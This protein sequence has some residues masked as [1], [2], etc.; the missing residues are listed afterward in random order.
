MFETSNQTK[1][2]TKQQAHS[3]FRSIALLSFLVGMICGP[4]PSAQAYVV[5]TSPVG[6]E[7]YWTFSEIPWYLD[8]NGSDDVSFEKLQASLAA[9]LDEWSTAECATLSFT[10]M[11]EATAPVDNALYIR[12][13]EDNFEIQALA[14]AAPRYTSDGKVLYSEIVFNGMEHTWTDIAVN[15]TG[16]LV[17]IQA[18]ATHEIG[19]SLGLTHPYSRDAS[20]FFTGGG[21]DAR[22]LGEDDKRGICYLFPSEE[23]ISGQPCDSCTQDAHCAVGTCV[24]HPWELSSFCGQDCAHDSDCPVDYICT[25][26]AKGLQCLPDHQF[27]GDFG[28]NIPFGEYCWD[29]TTCASGLCITPDSNAYC[30]EPCSTNAQCPVGGECTQGYC[31]RPACDPM[32]D[33]GCEPGKVCIWYQGTAFTPGADTVKGRCA[34][35]QGGAQPGDPCGDTEIQCRPNLLCTPDEEDPESGLS[36]CRK[37]CRVGTHEG[38]PSDQRCH[39]LNDSSTPDRGVCKPYTPPAPPEITEPETP[40]EEKED[41]A[42]STLTGDTLSPD[43]SSG[44]SQSGANPSGSVETQIQTQQ[45]S[46]SYSGPYAPSDGSSCSAARHSSN[47]GSGALL[48]L[49]L[50]LLFFVTRRSAQTLYQR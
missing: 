49:L 38:C 13:Q 16:S 43:G 3:F 27:C 1:P 5:I 4:P 10:Y 23:F 2:S 25:E 47:R 40:Q 33:N 42:S 29:K 15:A 36:F 18:V 26:T 46:A 30:S 32:Q 34:N 45:E 19:H 35:D 6:S 39:D 37:D 24:E 14:Y 28:G 44:T 8:V 7:L 50:G 9:A 31:L 20:M 48:L 17:D 22:K 21:M 41:V 12:F 11:G